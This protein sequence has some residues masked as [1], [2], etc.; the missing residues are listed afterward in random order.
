MSFTPRPDQQRVLEFLN[1]GG[2]L[3]VSAVPGSGKTAILSYLAAELVRQ[4]IRNEE[5]VLIVTFANSAVDNFTRRIR[6]FLVTPTFQP[7]QGEHESSP[8][9]PDVGYRVRTLHGLAHDILRERPALLGLPEDFDIIDERISTQIL[10][11]A[12]RNWIRANPQMFE[13]FVDRAL[14]ENYRKWLAREKWPELAIAVARSFIRRA[15]DYQL[16]PAAL[17]EQMPHFTD[18][19]AIGAMCLDIY[20]HYER[21]LRYRGGIDFDDLIR[22]ALLGLQTD[23]H[24]LDRLRARWPYILEDEAQDSSYLQERILRLLTENGNWV[25]VGDPNQ[26]INTTFTTSSIRFLNQFLT[27]PGVQEVQVKYSGRSNRRIIALANHLIDWTKAEHPDRNVRAN[28]FRPQHIE[29]TPPD[30]PQPNPIERPDDVVV[31]YNESLSPEKELD[32]VVKSIGRWLPQHSDRTCAV[33]VPDNQRGFKIS[34]ALEAAQLPHDDMLRS[35]VTTREA[36]RA[37]G[38]ILRYLAAPLSGSLLARAYQVW[39]ERFEES[40]EEHLDQND[41]DAEQLST[42]SPSG[43]AHALSAEEGHAGRDAERPLTNRIMTGLR[44][45]DQVEAY[46]WPRPDLDWLAAYKP[47]QEDQAMR[48]ELIDFRTVICRWLEA[49]AQLPIDQLILTI[50]Q[51]LYQSADLDR[52]AR[53]LALAHKLAVVLRQVADEHPAYRL[54]DLADELERVASNQERFI[55]FGEDDLGFA[56]KPGV[57]TVATMHKAKG[58]EWD[59][60]YLLGMN[61]YDFPSVEAHDVYRGETWYIR[62]GLN[63]EAEAVAQVEAITD[64]RDYLLSV[65]TEKARR[66]YAEERLRL[67]YVGITRATRELILTWNTGSRDDQPKQPAAPFIALHAFMESGQ[68]Q[69]GD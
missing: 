8:L 27:E 1:T 65:A 61:N 66:D 46:L 30:D 32:L 22:L 53:D 18:A 62:D 52:A 9:L 19:W 43:S 41:P 44:R 48:A 58:L 13:A 17:R 59:R 68:L 31:M 50:A 29:P 23:Q 63:L 40:E 42:S 28:A 14:D 3:G 47:A 57:V 51:D 33:L 45:C 10:D 55:G 16:T 35:T 67:L 36:A 26:S 37:L 38:H 12:V 4:R 69:D 56:A 20:E 39:V 15:K 2:Y 54:P 6:G 64:R 25:R 21:G 34:E 49:S 11:D 7:G 60:V 24:L 5:E